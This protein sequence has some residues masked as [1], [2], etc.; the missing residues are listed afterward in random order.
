KL[1]EIVDRG[2]L[3]D[4]RVLDGL[5]EQIRRFYN[6][7]SEIS[8]EVSEGDDKCPQLEIIRDDIH[9]PVSSGAEYE[10]IPEAYEQDEVLAKYTCMITQSPIRY[11]VTLKL[12]DAKS[13]IH[14]YT[15]ERKAIIKLFE[16]AT[17]VRDP[18]SRKTVTIEDYCE[19]IQKRKIIEARL[20]I[21]QGFLDI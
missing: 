2:R 13:T 17:R 7:G 14:E 5:I 20:A 19:D 16:N 10:D 21:L 3:R 1:I 11:P 6:G 4:T 12:R 8:L 15:Y 18:L 9:T